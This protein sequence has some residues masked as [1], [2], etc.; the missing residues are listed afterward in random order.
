MQDTL[1]EFDNQDSDT[2]DIDNVK[3]CCGT[4]VSV[5]KS[6]AEDIEMEDSP[7][8]DSTGTPVSE[9]DQRAANEMATWLGVKL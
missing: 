2:M 6:E 7:I 4:K 8:Y 3:E 9:S 1:Q 5:S